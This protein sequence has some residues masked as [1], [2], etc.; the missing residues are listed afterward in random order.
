M[1]NSVNAD[2]TFLRPN[3]LGNCSAMP[4][5]HEEAERTKRHQKCNFRTTFAEYPSNYSR[6][7]ACEIGVL[8]CSFCELAIG[9]CNL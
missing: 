8:G 1:L 3:N 9:A 7:Q 6:H 5:R 4:Q 2:A